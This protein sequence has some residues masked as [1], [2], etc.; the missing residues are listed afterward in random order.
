MTR[1]VK[2]VIL[3]RLERSDCSVVS[4]VQLLWQLYHLERTERLHPGNCIF[5]FIP[6]LVT[7]VISW[8]AFFPLA[9]LKGRAS[10][11]VITTFVLQILFFCQQWILFDNHCKIISTRS[12]IIWN[13]FHVVSQT[14]H[15]HILIPGIL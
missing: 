4:V 5:I 6:D 3:K 13:I 1:N 10:Y 7:L 14:L 2:A 15:V 11:W 8:H 9:S 12:G